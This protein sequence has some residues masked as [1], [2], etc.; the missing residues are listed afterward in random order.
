MLD[1]V[2][3]VLGSRKA[4]AVISAIALI[5]LRDVVGLDEHFANEIIKLVLLYVGTQGL[6][7]VTVAA[8]GA[9]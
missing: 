3:K 4:L 9:K 2:K 6:V 1:G 7:D 5:V 8:R